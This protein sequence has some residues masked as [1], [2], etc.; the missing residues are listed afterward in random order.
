M[1]DIKLYLDNTGLTSVG[2]FEKDNVDINPLEDTKIKDVY[3]YKSEYFRLTEAARR[4]R[5]GLRNMDLSL[6]FINMID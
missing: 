3:L 2:V 4:M 1:S 5:E 6:R